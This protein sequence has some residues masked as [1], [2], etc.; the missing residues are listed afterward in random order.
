MSRTFGTG[1]DSVTLWLDQGGSAPIYNVTLIGKPLR[2][3][4]GPAVRI[5]FGEQ[6]ETIR[7]YIKAKSSKGRAVLTMFGVTLA[8]PEMERDEEA[9]RPDLDIGE[10]IAAAISTFRVRNA[11]AKPIELDLGPMA[12]QFGFLQGCGERLEVL[13]SEPGRSLSKEARPPEPLEIDTWLQESDYPNYLSR[14]LMEG[15]L[16]YR[17]TVSKTGRATSCYVID[18]NKPQLFD[19]AMCLGL[20]RRARFEPARNAEGESV[21]S[22]YS[23]IVTFRMR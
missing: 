12:A 23:G 17:L 1:E 14:A 10:S 4:Y 8:Q 16:T 9:E 21:A 7:S 13:L 3:P 11:V 19:D 5:Q 22:Y 20:L 15:R 18:S 2:N 6:P